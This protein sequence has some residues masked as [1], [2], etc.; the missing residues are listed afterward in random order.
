MQLDRL[1]DLPRTV[2][3]GLGR[4]RGDSLYPCPDPNDDRGPAARDRLPNSL[5]NSAA[6][7]GAALPTR[8]WGTEAG[9]STRCATSNDGP[10]DTNS[11]PPK[12]NPVRGQPA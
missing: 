10:P 7:R 4:G 11:L 3:V 6:H 1:V 12:Q 9:S 8:H 2:N 5:R